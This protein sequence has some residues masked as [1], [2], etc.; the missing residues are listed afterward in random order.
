[1]FGRVNNQT[2]K[3]E[4]KTVIL[5]TNNHFGQKIREHFL[6]DAETH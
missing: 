4:R 1:M 3:P 2:I 5:C 6:G